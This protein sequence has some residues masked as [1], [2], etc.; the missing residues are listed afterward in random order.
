MIKYR[1]FPS[2]IF[3]I[4]DFSS[5]SIEVS[6]FIYYIKQQQFVKHHSCQVYFLITLALLNM[7][8]FISI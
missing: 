4:H 8:M 2:Y 3:T 1:N 6:S 5:R 7:V